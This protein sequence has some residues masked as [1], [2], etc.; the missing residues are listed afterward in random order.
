ML[1]KLYNQIQDENTDIRFLN[2]LYMFSWIYDMKIYD[3]NLNWDIHE[4]HEDLHHMWP[5]CAVT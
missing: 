5:R 3:M 1:M 2:S 4:D